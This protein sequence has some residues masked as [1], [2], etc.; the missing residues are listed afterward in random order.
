MAEPTSRESLARE[1]RVDTF[2]GSG[3]GGQHRNKVETAV[4]VT[5]LLSGLV[6]TASDSRSQA[7]NREMAFQRLAKKLERMKH[8]RKPRK[9]TR[10]T[11]ASKSR[12]LDSK[13]QRGEQKSLRRSRVQD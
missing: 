12:R 5:H 6:A 9:R 8:R 2:R 1:S 10:P 11:K 7:R 13:R 3:P 4:R